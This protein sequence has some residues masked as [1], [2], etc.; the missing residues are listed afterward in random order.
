M[1]DRRKSFRSRVYYGAR[2]TFNERRS[3]MDCLIRNVSEQGVRVELDNADVISDEVDLVINRKGLA[4]RA[5]MIWRRNGQAGFAFRNNRHVPTPMTLDWALQ[6]RAV[7]R[8]NK[9]LLQKLG[10]LSDR[11]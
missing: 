1:L 11:S 2:I 3:T 10:Q 9:T 5:R 8:A 7:E 6:L 4:Y